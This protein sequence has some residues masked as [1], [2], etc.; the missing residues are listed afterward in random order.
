MQKVD[1]FERVAKYNYGMIS[2]LVLGEEDTKVYYAEIE[3]LLR[4]YTKVSKRDG[5][6]HETFNYKRECIVKMTV[7]GKT[8]SVFTAD[9]AL[10]YENSAK[11]AETVHT[12]NTYSRFPYCHKINNKYRLK[13]V[14]R[15][16][17]N[18]LEKRGAVASDIEPID[19][20]KLLKTRS[21][22]QLVVEGLV[23]HVKQNEIKTVEAVKS[24]E[25]N[26]LMDDVVAKEEVLELVTRVK[27]NDKYKLE[28][29][30]IDTVSA[31]F[32]NGE[33]V[34]LEEVKKRVP[35]F[36]KKATA[37]KVL[38]RGIL[39]KKLTF[40]ADEYSMDAIKM[41]LLVGGTVVKN[42]KQ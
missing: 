38:A 27:K 17:T 22:E 20:S 30:N 40:L 15:L 18:M 2:K 37:L 19:Y 8:L 34:T 14:L 25:V 42:K 23:K 10:E 31:H 12:K 33:T 5:W 1:F 41:I 16:I 7:R 28:I 29:V 3:N 35:F 39:D 26:E 4:R 24:T 21:V 9:S 11:L 36:N 32:E 13:L 6:K